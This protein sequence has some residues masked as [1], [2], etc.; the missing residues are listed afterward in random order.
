MNLESQVRN[1]EAE[2]EEKAARELDEILSNPEYKFLTTIQT[3][4]E[5]IEDADTAVEALAIAMA[6]IEEREQRTFVMK[7]A[8][9]VQGVEQGE[10]SYRG[11]K[12][13]FNELVSKGK[14]IGEGGDADV[15][16]SE[17]E[18]RNG[19]SPICYKF[20]KQIGKNLGRNTLER[21]L[22]LHIAFYKNLKSFTSSVKVPSPYYYCEFGNHKIIA[23]ERLPARSVDDLVRGFGS[24]P[25]WVDDGVIN[26]FCDDLHKSLDFCHQQGLY[27]RDLHFGNIMF[28]Q[29]N[30][31]TDTLGYIIDFGVS[32]FG[33]EGLE[34]YKST[35]SRGTF[36]YADDYGRIEE[37]RSSLLRLK[38]KDV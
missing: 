14:S 5:V 11:F 20:A 10:I 12:R 25:Q 3:N 1:P 28:T 33:V 16:V 7:A 19:I 2:K 17:A 34:P 18:M 24:I 38:A 4:R 37:V 13:M 8:E 23:M 36:T 21:E 6:K 27:H 35:D 31:P 29:S 32:V 9:E 15:Y 26:Q 30:I 22:D